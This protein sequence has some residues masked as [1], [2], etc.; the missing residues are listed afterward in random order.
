MRTPSSPLSH[1]LG[2]FGFPPPLS[3]RPHLQETYFGLRAM[4]FNSAGNY[5]WFLPPVR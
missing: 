1:C 5:L 4:T 2:G 3:R